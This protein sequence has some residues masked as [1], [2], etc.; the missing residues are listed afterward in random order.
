M[1]GKIRLLIVAVLLLLVAGGAYLGWRH[2][3]AAPADSTTVEIEPVPGDTATPTDELPAESSDSEASPGEADLAPDSA[4][5]APASAPVPQVRGG[6]VP[7]SLNSLIA[8]I[9]ALHAACL[10]RR[11]CTEAKWWDI[12]VRLYATDAPVHLQELYAA[13]SRSWRGHL[14]AGPSADFDRD[15]AIKLMNRAREWG[16]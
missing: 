4:S 1:S 3:L 6:R 7:Q 15:L 2:F 8:E 11:G 5:P 10:E 14:E 13:V 16:Y 12:T 9:K